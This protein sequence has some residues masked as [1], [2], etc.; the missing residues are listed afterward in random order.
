MRRVSGDPWSPYD[1]MGAAY[2]EHAAANAYNAFYDRPSV[3]SLVGNVDGKRVLDACCGPGY[4]ARQLADRGADVV[5]FDASEEMVALARSA[6]VRVERAVLGERLPYADGA[7]DLVVCAL[8]IHYVEDRAAA[9]RELFRVLCPGGAVVL[10]TQHPTTDWLRKGGSYFE[11]VLEED[12]W[13][14][15]GESHV[16]RFWREPLT[17]LCAVIADAGFLI[18][19]LV[20]PLPADEMKERWPEHWEKLHR[21]PGFLLLRLVKPA[22]RDGEEPRRA[23]GS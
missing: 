13:E 2:E 23:G 1:A 17:T 16:V 12:V 10:S 19:R 14:R 20:E 11:V 7:F 15:D 9:F 3:L 8:A 5:A 18:D 6:G 4:Y 21:R 22:G